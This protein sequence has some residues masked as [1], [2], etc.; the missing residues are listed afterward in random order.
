MNTKNYF[1]AFAIYWGGFGLVTTFYPALMDLFLS[2]DGIKASTDFSNHVWMHGGIDI[3]ALVIV[4]LALSREKLSKNTIIATA[5]A[6]FFPTIAIVY[7]LVFTPY[8]SAL[9]IGSGLGTLLF[10]VWGLYIG[11]KKEKSI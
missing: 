11:L 10:F 9:F 6:A 3:L 7:S 8:W 2:N 4:L 1:I 5:F